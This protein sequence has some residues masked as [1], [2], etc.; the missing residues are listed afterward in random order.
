MIWLLGSSIACAFAL[1]AG[2]RWKLDDS[3]RSSRSPAVFLHL[4]AS[5]LLIAIIFAGLLQVV[6][7]YFSIDVDASWSDELSRLLLVWLVFLGSVTAVLEREHIVFE[8][9]MDRAPRRVARFVAIVDDVIVAVLAFATV[10]FSYPVLRQQAG[11]ATA[12]LGWPRAVFV[13]ALMLGLSLMAA[14]S[15]IQGIRICAGRN[16]SHWP[17]NRAE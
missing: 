7:R 9:V 16:S 12:S 6:V 3:T 11:M 15:L 1:E 4:S 8:L 13:S 2:Y 17:A 5:V 10:Y 14:A